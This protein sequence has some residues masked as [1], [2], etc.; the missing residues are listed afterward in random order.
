MDMRTTTCINMRRIM[1]PDCLWY[2]P[3]LVVPGTASRLASSVA[4]ARLAAKLRLGRSLSF[5]ESL[6]GRQY[7]AGR[8]G[9]G[10]PSGGGRHAGSHPKG[11]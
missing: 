7:G 9:D 5:F 2:T 1:A 11:P 10:A 8:S 6:I 3:G 4:F